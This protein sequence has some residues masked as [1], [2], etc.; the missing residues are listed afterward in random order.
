MTYQQAIDYYSSC[1]LFSVSPGLER[2]R[3]VLNVLGNPQKDLRYIHIAGTNGKGSVAAML[4]SIFQHAGYHTGLFTSPHLSRFNERIQ[5]NNQPI[6]DN[7]LITLTQKLS[8]AVE[9]STVSLSYFEAVTAL[10]FL[11]FSR[12]ECDIVILE[13]GLGGRLDAT[14]VIDHPEVSIITNI[15]FDHTQILGD[16]LEKIAAEKAGIIK[17]DSDVILSSKQEEVQ[18][19]VEKVCKKQ[20]AFLHSVSIAQIINHCAQGQTLHWQGKNYLLPLLGTHQVINAS[21]ALQA[22][23]V[24]ANKGWNLSQESIE[25]GLSATQWP[26][27]FEIMQQHPYVIVDGAHNPQGVLSMLESLKLYFPN[28]RY[29]FIMGMM[30]DKD[31]KQC[32]ILASQFANVCY[33]VSPEGSRALDAQTLANTLQKHCKQ[34]HCCPQLSHA[35]SHALAQAMPEDVICIFGSLYQ[36]NQARSYPYTTV[37]D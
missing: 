29:H 8:D 23:A 21:T 7:D 10:G 5:I 19:T 17:P 24:L 12:K 31:W 14:N 26:G 35:I 34:V 6:D 4:A 28:R 11:Y 1:A 13:A 2:L 36:L 37:I 20:N 16:T 33:A 25:N 15:G 3:I 18:I 32:A 22:T 9:E 30:A 27:R